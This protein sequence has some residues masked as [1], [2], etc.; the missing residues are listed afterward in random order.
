MTVK[1]AE[2]LR[3][4]DGESSLELLSEVKRKKKILE[5]FRALLRFK[6]EAVNL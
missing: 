1:T 5:L 3:E 4:R 6:R 2:H